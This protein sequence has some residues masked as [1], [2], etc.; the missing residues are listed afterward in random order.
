MGYSPKN[1]KK[2]YNKLLFIHK[3]TASG[4]VILTQDVCLERFNLAND[5]RFLCNTGNHPQ[6]QAGRSLEHQNLNLG[7]HK[8]CKAPI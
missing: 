3:T 6:D 1:R 5:K 7:N 4:S 2:K 8:A